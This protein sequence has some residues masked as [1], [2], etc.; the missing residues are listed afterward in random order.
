MRISDWSSDV[1]SSDLKVAV[2]TGGNSGIGKATAQLFVQQEARVVV[3]GRRKEALDAAVSELGPAAIRVTGD[4]ADLDLHQ[5]LPDED[6]WRVGGLVSYVANAAVTPL[7][8]WG[9]VAVE[10][11]GK[12]AYFDTHALFSS[13]S[14]V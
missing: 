14:P 1:C 13:T 7:S 12:N 4:V 5:K 9:K 11:Y 6:L 10:E 8:S 2:I 3:T